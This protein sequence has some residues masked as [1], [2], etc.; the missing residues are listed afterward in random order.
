MLVLK[1][2]I[3]SVLVVWLAA[4]SDEVKVLSEVVELSTKHQRELMPLIDTSPLLRCWKITQKYLRQTKSDSRWALTVGLSAVRGL[5]AS[6]VD[7]VVGWADWGGGAEVELA[8]GPLS[9]VVPCSVEYWWGVLGGLVVRRSLFPVTQVFILL[10]RGNDL[11]PAKKS[12]WKLNW[13]CSN[14]FL[15]FFYDLDTSWRS[16]RGSLLTLCQKAWCFP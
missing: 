14:W 12:K 6:S 10:T 5:R 2:Q 9:A 7:A 15:P 11:R 13:C 3:P 8:D 16:E 4:S 1:S